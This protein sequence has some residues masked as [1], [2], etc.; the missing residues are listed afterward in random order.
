VTERWLR[1][2]QWTFPREFRLDPGSD[3]PEFE[4]L[5]ILLS[6][7]VPPDVSA[8]SAPPPSRVV[9]AP[10]AGPAL[11][12]NAEFVIELCNTHFR[13]RRNAREMGV[14]SPESAEGRRIA[15]AVEKLEQVLG[16]HRIECV[17]LEGKEYDDGRRD[18]EPLAVEDAPP[19]IQRP[20]IGRCERPVIRLN[21]ALIQKGRGI[22]LRPAVMA[23]GG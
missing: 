15:S 18:F 3:I 19:S 6:H 16:E 21:G 9:E 1:F 14:K 7:A 17:D 12:G 2:R 22:V 23:A 13:L 5:R 8:S 10:P 11:S 4:A 20:T